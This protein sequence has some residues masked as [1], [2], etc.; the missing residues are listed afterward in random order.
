MTQ[1]KVK[2]GELSKH[3]INTYLEDLKKNNP[4]KNILSVEFTV[5]GDSVDTKF[6]YESVPFHR[7]RRITGYLV[8]D[9][10]RFN[11][12]KHAEVNDR[13]NHSLT[14]NEPQQI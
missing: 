12:A 11:D 3:E 6:K 14:H 13:V 1:V 4:D 2:G 9:L 10:D 8:G 7:I 5:D